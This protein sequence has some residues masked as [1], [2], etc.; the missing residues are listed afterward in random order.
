[1]KGRR[2]KKPQPE[3]VPEETQAEVLETQAEVLETANKE[4]DE[5]EELGD[6][7]VRVLFSETDKEVEDG[8]NAVVIAIALVVLAV[9]MLERENPQSTPPPPP[10]TVL[11]AT[12]T[13]LW[14][15]IRLP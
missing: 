1:M 13:H 12:L 8:M 2:T 9:Y 6:K 7:A 15:M 5:L 10:P 11:S 14:S 4:Q 3:T